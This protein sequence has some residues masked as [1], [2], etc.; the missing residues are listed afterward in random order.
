MVGQYLDSRE[1]TRP[2]GQEITCKGWL[3]KV[4]LY[5]RKLVI[6]LSLQT[7]ADHVGNIYN[8]DCA[9]T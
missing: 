6:I 8:D 9:F 1:I 3:E 7:L 5:I 2:S 4:L